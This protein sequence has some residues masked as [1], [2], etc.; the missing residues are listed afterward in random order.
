MAIIRLPEKD[1]FILSVLA[2]VSPD[3]PWSVHVQTLFLPSIVNFMRNKTLVRPVIPFGKVSCCGNPGSIGQLSSLRFIEEEAE[4]L[5]RSSSRAHEDMGELGWV[6]KLACADN[7][8]TGS[9]YLL[10]PFGCE[11]ELGGTGIS[12]ILGPLGLTLSN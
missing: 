3:V 11:V 9:Q 8:L 4:R 12:S 10:S 5:M 2:T 7:Y 1:A 6:N